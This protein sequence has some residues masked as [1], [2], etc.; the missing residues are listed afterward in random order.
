[1][2]LSSCVS[3]GVEAVGCRQALHQAGEKFDFACLCLRVVGKIEQHAI[4]LAGVDHQLPV[5]V[6]QAAQTVLNERSPPTPAVLL[7]P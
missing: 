4:A 3:W 6:D 5:A 2:I 7:L 1:M